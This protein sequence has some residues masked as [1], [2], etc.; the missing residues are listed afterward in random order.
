MISEKKENHLYLKLDKNE[1]ES[2]DSISQSLF[3]SSDVIL[4]LLSFEVLEDSF[5]SF[6]KQ[7]NL[8]IEAKGFC[9]V[10]VIKETPSLY[11]VESLKVIPTLIEAEDYIQ[12]EQI[13][14]DLGV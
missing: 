8:S 5:L 14:R 1:P 3:V 11:D 13:Q 7:I 10:I 4:D 12:M 2:F 6:L 9:L